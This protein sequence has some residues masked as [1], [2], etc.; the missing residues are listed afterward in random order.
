MTTGPNQP[1]GSLRGVGA[2]R[3]VLFEKLGLR[4]VED[5]F[6][7]FPRRYEDR[8]TITP[9][10][11]IQE[12]GA[13]VVAV[14]IEGVDRIRTRRP[15]VFRYTASLSDQSG[16][17]RA[18]WFGG[19]SILRGFS[20]PARVWLYGKARLMGGVPEFMNPEIEL[21]SEGIKGEAWGCVLPVYPLTEGLSGKWL[22]KFIHGQL[23]ETLPTLPEKLPEKIIKK[24]RLLPLL[25]AIT[26]MHRPQSREHWALSRKRLAYEECFI[27][28]LR[29]EQWRQKIQQHSTA[30]L[31][32]ANLSY[33]I[34]FFDQLPFTLTS[35]QRAAIEEIIFDMRGPLPMNR[36]LQGDVGSGKTIV[37]LA[38]A[39][40]V[41][42][43][44]YNAALMAPTTLL[45]SQ[46]HEVSKS[47]FAPFSIPCRLITGATPA[48]E[49][50]KIM[51]ELTLGA[52][53]FIV[54]THALYS[55][56][57]Q[58]P[59]LGLAIIDEQHR[60][61]VVQRALFA[62]KGDY[63]HI[64]T[65]SG[66]PIP[67]TLYL[68]LYGDLPISTLTEKPMGRIPVQTRR[69]SFNQLPRL[70]DFIRKE[71][72]GGGQVYW[73]CPLIEGDAETLLSA[74]QRILQLKKA[75]PNV[76]IAL[77]HGRMAEEEKDTVLCSFLNKETSFLVATTVVEVGVD[78]PAATVMVIEGASSFGLAQLHQLRGR[79]GRGNRRSVCFLL[80]D[81]TEA[82][83]IQRLAVLEKSTD[84]FYIAEQDLLLRGTGDIGGNR[85]HGENGF[86][87]VNLVSDVR[88]MEWAREDAREYNN[89]MNRDRILT[90]EE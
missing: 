71:I 42:Q 25:S 22:R 84:G 52:P 18:V 64:L 10:Q 54:G 47:I 38:A 32:S 3:V 21:W 76:P 37:A 56:G 49:R 58:L 44:G 82:I 67:R 15:A 78:V 27:Y 60:F 83:A 20:F 45:A 36:L 69:V 17:A 8:R 70:I 73:V 90:K 72:A 86:R 6:W 50:R 34:S 28:Q 66:T 30:P 24:R 40:G 77:L 39:F 35:S 59:R 68:A 31:I 48:P 19:L 65:M 43:S 61:G 85:Q 88:L 53:L 79:V 14:F 74:E 7:Y 75:L 2:K 13:Y 29:L 33:P 1:L 89:A 5:L 23:K 62:A 26:G 81:S 4:R 11:S 46:L 12:E 87:L 55:E 51:E 9:L 41:L 63:P 57:V 16:Q 80:D